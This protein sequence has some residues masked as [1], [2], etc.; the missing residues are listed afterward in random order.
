[1]IVHLNLSGHGRLRKQFAAG[2][3]AEAWRVSVESKP[4]RLCA[5]AR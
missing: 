2:R 4:E 5:A 3:L 1:M